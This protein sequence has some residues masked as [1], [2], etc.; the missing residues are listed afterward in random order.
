MM[1]S[2]RT[3]NDADVQK[4]PVKSI[5]QLSIRQIWRRL[6]LLCLY[7]AR[8]LKL[9]DHCTFNRNLA[10]DLDIKRLQANTT[11]KPD[12]IVLYWLSHSLSAE[13][14]RDL[15]RCFKV[16]IVWVLLDSEPYTGGCH[17]AL[18][19]EK[20][21]SK[22]GACP[23]LGSSYPSDLSRFTWTEKKN[24]LHEVP[25]VFMAPTLWLQ[26][27]IKSSA[28][29]GGNRIEHL[30]LPLGGRYF[31]PFDKSVARRVLQL[32][33]DS[34]IILAG[35]H[36]MD[37]PRKGMQIMKESLV[38]L[39]IRLERDRQFAGREICC[40]FVGNADPELSRQAP[41]PVYELGYLRSELD[42]SLAY[43]AADVFVSPS[44]EDAGP[45]M[46]SQAMMC[47]APAVAFRATG[48]ASELINHKENGYLVETVSSAEMSEGIY[49]MLAS[50]NRA[51][52]KSSAAET[53]RR[54]HEPERI[55][56]RFES[57]VM[58][59]IDDEGDR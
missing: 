23:M 19:C 18:G 11:Q 31:R 47:G 6:R 58:S 44:L 29:F 2:C 41:F 10:P 46:L 15:Y 27:Q 57:L 38:L 35:C 7:R 5:H 4:I 21:K 53:A 50:D 48:I 26:K 37:D 32:P 16:P 17:Y 39:K 40:V 25:I 9:A 8:A 1:V 20:F 28:L 43:Q 55:L 54:Y 51:K 30:P 22:C 56:G 24:I 59:I 3:S 52:L 36:K 14:I 49:A 12:A 34:L 42:L 45:L 33:Q 13:G